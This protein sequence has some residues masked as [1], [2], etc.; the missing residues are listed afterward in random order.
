MA[1]VLPQLLGI[2]IV[3]LIFAVPAG[4]HYLVWGRWLSQA[5]ERFE[6]WSRWVQA[7]A[8]ELKSG[9]LEPM[10]QAA[11]MVERHLEGFRRR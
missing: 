7:E 6:S 3:I 9:L 11:A 1:L 5:R 4:F 8:A 10:R 2:L